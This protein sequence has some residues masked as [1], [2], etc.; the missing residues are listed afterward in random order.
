M[1]R[2]ERD[3]EWVDQ[4]PAYRSRGPYRDYGW[5][6]GQSTLP[7]FRDPS[8]RRMPYE[9]E[10]KERPG[11]SPPR[12]GPGWRYRGYQG[13]EELYGP[14]YGHRRPYGRR[15]ARRADVYRQGYGEDWED[16]YEDEWLVPGPFSGVG[17]RGYVRSSRRIYE[18]VCERLTRHGQIDPSN[19]EIRV[20]DGEITLRGTVKSR[21]TKRR[22]EDV[23]ESVPG[24]RD[25][26]NRLRIDY[27][28]EESAGETDTQPQSGE[29]G[30]GA[31]QGRVDRVGESGVYPASGPYPPDDAELQGMASWGQGER[32]AKGYEDHGESEIWY[33]EEERKE[34]KEEVEESEGDSP[35]I[36]GV[37]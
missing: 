18:D 29:P 8:V 3:D 37:A 11:W 4:I 25:I 19:V 15:R 33:T 28:Q 7:E 30:G 2:H 16:Y 27:Q 20:E 36:A 26:H 13:E 5:E 10:I 32:G 35:R 12:R 9:E 22:I 14:P 17:P 24:V 23:A 21:R 31:G 1:P 6:R 34:I